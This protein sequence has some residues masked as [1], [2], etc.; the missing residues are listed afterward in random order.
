MIKSIL[1]IGFAAAL[2][3]TALPAQTIPQR[4]RNQ[5]ER[6]GRGLENGTLGAGQAAH[7]ERQESRINR[8][9]ARDRAANG[10]HLTPAERNRVSRQ[11]D[12]TSREIR[13]DRL[14]HR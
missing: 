9:V 12:H 5:Q 6:I 11:L 7:I 8:E 2:V 10:G 1:T 3:T 14:S 4:E 13:R